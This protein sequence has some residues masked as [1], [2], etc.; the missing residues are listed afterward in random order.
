M[1]KQAKELLSLQ[2]FK[3]SKWDVKVPLLKRFHSSGPIIGIS[4]S[5]EGLTCAEIQYQKDSEIIVIK[6]KHYSSNSEEEMLKAIASFAKG[7]G[8][9]YA[10]LLASP[11]MQIMKLEKSLPQKGINRL[12]DVKHRM[13]E[14]LEEPEEEGR[15]YAFVCNPQFAETLV[16]SYDQVKIDYT[17]NLVNHAGL[18]VVRVSCGIYSILDYL[19][20]EKSEFL[21][22]E[23]ILVINSNDSLIVASIYEG[24]FQQLGFR[25]GVEKKELECHIL[26]MINRFEYPHTEISYVNCSDWDMHEFCNQHYPNLKTRSI[27][28]DSFKGLFQAVSYG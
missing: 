20:N 13:D 28:E 5:H 25:H 17:A 18:E 6:V 9:S 10:I 24:R 21:T 12:Y 26:G 14:I 4:I 7:N 2:A 8:L 22:R 15:A 23:Q 27:F 1:L 11:D 16:F 19:L 3:S